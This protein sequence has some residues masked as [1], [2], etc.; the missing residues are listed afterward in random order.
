V[1]AA[2]AGLILGARVARAQEVSL[3]EGLYVG[4]APFYVAD[5]EKLW[6]KQGL[7]PNVVTFSAG[8]LVLDA[9]AGDRALLGTAAET[10][11]T[12]AVLNGLPIRVIATFNTF[13]A[14]DVAAISAIRTPADLKGKKIGFFTGTNAHYY[15]QLLLAKGGLRLGDVTAVSMAPPELVTSLVKGDLDAFV[16]GE[17]MTSQAVSQAGDRVHILR[18]PVGYTSFSTVI[19]TQ[20]A[21]DTQPDTLVRALRALIEATEFIKAHP[22]RAARIISARV[23]VD[24]KIVAKMLASMTHEVTL[25]RDALAALM[26]REGQWAIDARVARPGAVLPDYKKVLVPD[27]LARAKGQVKAASR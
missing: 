24:E 6:E 8:R 14:V 16:W 18:D 12:L 22:D 5:A 7:R 11:P 3:G 13:H 9:V 2:T 15:L 26:T 23:K 1:L 10:P 20:K 25:D 17:P 21:I 4:W 19:T 27:L